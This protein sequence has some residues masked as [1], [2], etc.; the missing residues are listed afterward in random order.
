MLFK[1]FVSTYNVEILNS[2]NPYLHLID[3]ESSIKNKLK[4]LLYELGGFKFVT[5]LVLVFKKIESRGKIKYDNFCL[6]SKAERII[7]KSDIVMKVM[8]LN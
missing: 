7:N 4:K 3:T 5:R 1:V 2:F 8:C 6:S